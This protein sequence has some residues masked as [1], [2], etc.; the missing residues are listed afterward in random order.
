MGK[1]HLPPLFVTHPHLAAEWHPTRN[2][3]I[4]IDQVSAA[5]NQRVWWSCRTCHWDWETLMKSRSAS[6]SGCP[7][8]AGRVAVPGVNSLADTHPDL[9]AEWHPVRNGS[10]TPTQ[11]KPGSS[12]K[13]WWICRSCGWD[14]AVSVRHRTK[15]SGCPACSG[16]VAVPGVNSLADTH[17]DL[18]A[19][20]H[21]TLNDHLDPTRLKAGSHDRVWWRCPI[22][23]NNWEATPNKRSLGRG[24]PRCARQASPQGPTRTLADACPGLVDEWDPTNDCEPTDVQAGS[25]F[26]ATWCCSTCGHRWIAGVGHRSRGQGC[27]S[28][29]GRIAVAGVNSMLD[30][31]PDLANEW[32]PSRNTAL[33]PADLKAGSNKKVWWCC[34]RCSHDWQASP[35]NRTNTGTG[36]PSCTGRVVSVERALA[37]VR[38]ELVAEWDAQHNSQHAGQVAAYS[39]HVAWWRCSTC[40]YA[41]EATIA[42]RTNGRGCPACAGK[43]LVPGS[44]TLADTHPELATEWSPRNG[45]LTP[46]DVSFGMVTKVWWRCATCHRDWHAQPNTRTNMASGCPYCARGHIS[47]TEQLLGDLIARWFP[48]SLTQ[49]PIAVHSSRVIRVD[50]ALPSERIAIEYDGCYWHRDSHQKDL[51]R[52]RALRNAGWWVLRVREEPLPKIEPHDVVLATSVHHTRDRTIPAVATLAHITPIIYQHIAQTRRRS[53]QMKLPGSGGSSNP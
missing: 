15:G 20:W 1:R 42:N 4:R 12:R 36:C 19:E 28:C 51:D 38:P 13:A 16:R 24:C 53:D 37:A 26:R 40:G 48:H 3:D 10:F 9:V 49:H 47:K 52:N 33:T 5:S 21:P 34:S 35:N 18:V 14:W 22:C 39:H 8:C 23:T 25:H 17:P 27:P 7:A 44:N 45:E 46:R 6:G 32:H 11:I 30:T 50:I 31:H 29:S 43:A 41:W 2:G